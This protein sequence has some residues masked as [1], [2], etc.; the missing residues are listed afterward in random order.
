M[1]KQWLPA[2]LILPFFSTHAKDPCTQ[3]G[4]QN[5][6]ITSIDSGES[7]FADLTIKYYKDTKITITAAVCW[8]KGC[9]ALP[10]KYV[11][12]GKINLPAKVKLSRN[13][14]C[15][16]G[17]ANPEC[18]ESYGEQCVID[19]LKL[20]SIPK[21]TKTNAPKTSS[22]TGNVRIDKQKYGIKVTNCT[23]DFDGED[24]CTD[25][26]LKK[27][28]QVLKSRK[29]NFDRDKIL[30]I[31]ASNDKGMNNSKALRAVVIEKKTA[32]VSSLYYALLP[33][34]QA[35]N[36]QGDAMEFIFNAQS[37]KFCFRGD[38]Y[39]YRNAYDYDPEYYPEFCFFYDNKNKE[40]ERG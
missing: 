23:F 7:L 32:V 27:Y 37:N 11:N 29:A 14:A 28:A 40:L 19:D 17:E 2:L 21:K 9:A 34:N 31:F 13:A 38:I 6:H 24:F 1:K 35:V 16:G 10:E 39:A 20:L 12:K 4:W 15:E 5:A 3:K 36:S 30:F 33:A 18:A 25:D 8:A 26:R 22:N